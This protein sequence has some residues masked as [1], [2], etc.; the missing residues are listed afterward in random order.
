MSGTGRTLAACQTR[1]PIDADLLVL[2]LRLPRDELYARLDARTDA[3]FAAGLVDEVRRLR[4]E[5]RGETQPLRGGVGYKEVSAYLDGD[6][7]YDE[8]VRRMKNANHR[9]VRR[10]N[11]WFKETDVRILWLDAG[12][13]AAVSAVE[14]ARAWLATGNA[15][16][17][18]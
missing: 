2:G 3:M 8:A 7:D 1:Q 10:Q 11:A 16:A 15:A 12:P 14:Q 17:S 5:G 4:A 6:Y 13:A 9:L 18:S